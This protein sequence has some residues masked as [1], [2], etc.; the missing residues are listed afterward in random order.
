MKTVILAGGLGSR[1]SEETDIKPKPLVEVGGKPILWHIMKIYSHYGF[2]DFVICLG[3]K[4]YLIK[5]YFINYY[6][7]TS[8]FTVNL[9]DNSI[10]FHNN[11][12]EDWKITLIDTGENTMTGGRIK[13]ILNYV[14]DN[15][16]MTY[17]D[18][19]SDVNILQLLEHHKKFNKIATVT[20]VQPPGRFGALAIDQNVVTSF[21][22]KPIGDSNFINGGFFVLNKKI[23]DYIA[24]DSTVFEQAPLKNLV[25]DKNLTAFHHQGFWQPMDTLREKNMLNDMWDQNKAPWKLWD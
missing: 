12:S 5:E 10:N 19:L 14:D 4:G 23:K 11:K 1:L 15:F 22:E 2:N 25:N 17:G 6:S 9:H 20:A 13:K 16:F 8:D 24:D 18:G 3:Y 7:H 21:Y